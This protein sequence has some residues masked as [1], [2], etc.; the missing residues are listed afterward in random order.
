MIE[1]VLREWT[2][3]L[4][5]CVEA[6]AAIIIGIAVI[7]ATIRALPLFV[8]RQQTPEAKE[9]VRLRLG[10]WL[11]VAPEFELRADILRTAISPTWTQIGRLAAFATLRTPL[12]YFL[13]PAIDRAAA[14][15]G[16][17]LTATPVTQ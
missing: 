4:A 8:D 5:N 16:R 12:N 6:I 2:T 10:R 15:E 1:S 9:D 7:E 13:Q 17:N 11:A 14:R 3:A